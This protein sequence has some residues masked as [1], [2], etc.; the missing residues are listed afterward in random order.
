P[1]PKSRT[2]LRSALLPVGFV[3]VRS[4]IALF[5]AALACRPA[6]LPVPVAGAHVIETIGPVRTGIVRGELVVAPAVAVTV[7]S[8]LVVSVVLASPLGLVVTVFAASVP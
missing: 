5:V 7:E 3:T 6:Q 2:T 4:A 8:T 1:S